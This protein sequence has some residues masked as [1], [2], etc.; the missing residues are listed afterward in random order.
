MKF[1]LDERIVSNGKRKKYYHIQCAQ[2]LNILP[3]PLEIV[4]SNESNSVTDSQ[5]PRPSLLISPTQ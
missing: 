3:I 2:R 1:N 4:L 5:D